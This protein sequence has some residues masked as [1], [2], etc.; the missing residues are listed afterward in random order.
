M[1][2]SFVLIAIL[3]VSIVICMTAF[4]VDPNDPKSMEQ[5]E[6]RIKNDVE[7]LKVKQR[8][9]KTKQ[10]SGTMREI[11]ALRVIDVNE[12]KTKATKI[13]DDVIKFIELKKGKRL[14][15][16]DAMRELLGERV[17][18]PEAKIQKQNAEI[19]MAVEF[20]ISDPN[21]LPD[22]NDPDY[23]SEIEQLNEFVEAINELCN[24][25]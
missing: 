14:E 15:K 7:I 24:P 20:M 23:V 25:A 11:L 16:S 13:S 18:E 19:R 1:K 2:R 6:L 12:V 21:F 4:A 5:E 3:V 17:K 9:L 22:S 10:Y 8:E